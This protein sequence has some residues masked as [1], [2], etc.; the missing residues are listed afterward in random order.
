MIYKYIFYKFYSW[1]REWYDPFVPQITA[2]LIL[3]LL[4]LS[5]PYSILLLA[6]YLN[7]IQFSMDYIT[8]P[9]VIAFIVIFILLVVF[10]QIY[11]FAYNNWKQ[12]ILFFRENDI[13]KWS[14]IAAYLYIIFCTSVYFILLI[15]FGYDF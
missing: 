12:I 13:S 10:N 15:F 3:S 2:T 9:F 1:A 8:S 6:S 11:F 4:P 5:I 7:I 14:K